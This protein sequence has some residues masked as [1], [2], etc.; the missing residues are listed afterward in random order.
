MICSPLGK[1]PIPLA[2]ARDLYGS[3]LIGAIGGDLLPLL[4]GYLWGMAKR[5]SASTKMTAG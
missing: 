4:Q 5:L 2:V 1:Y 3:L